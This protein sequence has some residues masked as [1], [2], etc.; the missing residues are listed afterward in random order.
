MIDNNNV[1]VIVYDNSLKFINYLIYNKMKYESLEKCNDYFLLVI[2]YEDYKKIKRRYKTKIVKYYGKRNIKNIIINN[3]YLLISFFI[4]LCVLYLL[5][6]TIF[7]IEI[8]TTD[9][10]VK[11]RILESLNNNGISLYKKKKSFKDLAKIKEKILNENEDILEWIEIKNKGCIYKIELTKR[12]INKD[13]NDN[14][15]PSSIIAE[16]D[17]LIKHI[18]VSSGVKM[19]EINE[20]VKK[21]DI[22]ISGNVV[23][24]NELITQ[25]SSDGEVYA[26]TWYY[27]NITVPFNYIEY[28]PTNKI[29]NHYYLDIFGH[30]FTLIGKYDSNKTLN[31]KKLILDKPYLFFK[32]YKEEKQVYNYKEYNINEDEAYKKA[33]ESSEKQILKRLDKDEYIIS[34]KVLKKEVNSSKIYLE[35]FFKVYENIA[36]STNVEE[37]VPQTTTMG[38]YEYYIGE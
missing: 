21:G 20:Y 3:K 30:E 11:T 13:T 27:V 24:N 6:N 17:G 5:T 23:K 1:K 35:V 25:I 8:N 34:K 29:V 10:V 37:F 38:E 19:K 2:D 16:K 32:L 18:T 33:I 36:V 7:K 15:S 12:V 31:T 22:L 26:E 28:E 9:E 14:N 4:S